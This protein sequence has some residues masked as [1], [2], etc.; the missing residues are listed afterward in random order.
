MKFSNVP[1]DISITQIAPSL[2]LKDL[3]SF[4]LIS[5]RYHGIC[6]PLLTDIRNQIKGKFETFILENYELP[7]GKVSE[8]QFAGFSKML[9]LSVPKKDSKSRG[10]FDDLVKKEKVNKLFSNQ[11]SCSRFLLKFFAGFCEGVGIRDDKGS[12]ALM[13]A[14]FYQDLAMVKLFL[15]CGAD[16]GLKNNAGKTARSLAQTQLVEDTANIKEIISLLDSHLTEQGTHVH[17]LRQ[18]SHSK[19]TGMQM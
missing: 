10:F 9:V 11:E 19:R 8:S 3:A 14:A 17:A 6:Q 15:D 12:T 4:A 13:K 1:E 18:L 7:E 5:K 16:A 2:S